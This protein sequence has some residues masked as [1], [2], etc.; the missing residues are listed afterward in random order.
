MVAEAP[1]CIQV[2]AR[3]VKKT[4]TELKT[5]VGVDFDPQDGAARELLIGFLTAG[6]Q[7]FLQDMKTCSVQSPNRN[8][9][10]GFLIHYSHHYKEPNRVYDQEEPLMFPD[11]IPPDNY[12]HC[13][14][15]WVH[16]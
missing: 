8:L 16:I 6:A 1:L 3:F 13:S 2:A 4:S 5:E 10:T 12:T 15:R 7:L 11:A 9:L 14:G